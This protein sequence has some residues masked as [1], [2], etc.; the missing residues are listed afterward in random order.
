MRELA[1]EGRT[2]LIVTHEIQFAAE[3]SDRG[4][5]MDGGRSSRKGRRPRSSSTPRTSA[6]ARSCARSWSADAPGNARVLDQV[7]GVVPKSCPFSGP[8][9]A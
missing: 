6:R 8:P 4:T 5:F 2:M 3:V 7:L 9:P 1:E